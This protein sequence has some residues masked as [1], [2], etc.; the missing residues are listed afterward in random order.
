MSTAANNATR[1]YSPDP[2]NRPSKI[3]AGDIN[4]DGYTDLLYVVSNPA[5][6]NAYGSIVLAINEAGTI[7]FNNAAAN[8][9]DS[10]YYLVLDDQ[11]SSNSNQPLSALDAQFASFFDF[12]ELG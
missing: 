1:L 8:S 2:I 11:A 9:A 4:I 3:R 12:D 10:A 7:N 6:N 5:S